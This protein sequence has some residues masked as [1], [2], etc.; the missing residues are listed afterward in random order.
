MS[1][2]GARFVSRRDRVWWAVLLVGAV[3]AATVGGSVSRP[4]EATPLRHRHRVLRVGTWRG[5][6]GQFRRIQDAVD[7]A[8]PGDWILVAPGRYHEQG[9][10]RGP[11]PGEAGAAVMVRTPGVHVRGMDRNR[12]VLDGTKPGAPRCSSADADQD[13]GRADVNGKPAGRNGIEVFEVDGVS[14]DNLTACNFLN[15]DGGG[16]NAIWWNGGDGTGTQ[17]LGSFRGSYLSATSTYYRDGRPDAEYGLF[18]SNTTGPGRLAHTYASNMGDAGYYV[19]ACPNCD[20]VL[21]DAHAQ[22]SALGYSGTNSGGRLTIR[23]SEFDQNNT[24]VVTNSQNN[25]DAP[26]PQD[27]ACPAGRRRVRKTRSCW[28]FTDNYVHDNNNPNVPSSGSAA[29]GPPGAGLVISGGRNDTVIGNRFVRNG[30]WAVLVVPFVDTDTPPL[31]AHCQ[32][33]VEDFLNPGWCYYAAWGDEVAH[34]TF[35]DN[36]GFGNPTNGDLADLSELHDPGNCWHGNR[37]PA[38]VTTAPADL[39]LTNSRCGIP[40][41][42]AAILGSDLSNQVICATEIFGPCPPAPGMSYPRAT[43]IVLPALRPQPTMPNP[44]SG[45]PDNPWCPDRRDDD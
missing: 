26:S 8:R 38:G 24:G 28:R 3:V 25:D 34:N 42:G 17:N 21:S 23:G 6:P 39:Q 35:R 40:H 14:V 18:V 33:G 29:L 7:A 45:V 15:G 5:R 30:S 11:V 22:Y 1:G 27:G 19:G 20:T 12:V 31:V 4:A 13:L 16:G 32:G 36:G 10:R 37:D 44:C 41:Q 2:R 43:N 9:D